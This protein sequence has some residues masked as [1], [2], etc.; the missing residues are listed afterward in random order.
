MLYLQH[1]LHASNEAVVDCRVESS[2]WQFFRGET[3]LQRGI[4]TDASSI[5]CCS[6]RADENGLE[7]LLTANI[8]VARRDDVIKK[9]STQ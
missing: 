6:T 5:T 1:T 2:Y 7:T 3:Y 9:L 8:E 4:S